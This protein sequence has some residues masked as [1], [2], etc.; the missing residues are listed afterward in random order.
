MKKIKYIFPVLFLLFSNNSTF[1][2]ISCNIPFQIND[3]KTANYSSEIS[4]TVEANFICD[5]PIEP[6]INPP[7]NP[8][9]TFSG[10]DYHLS[11]N[12]I[13]DKP[14]I[15]VEGLDPLNEYSAY[16]LYR[17]IPF[18]LKNG[19]AAT[20]RDIVTI[21]FI[22]NT[23]SLI[24]NA[25][26]LKNF[27]AWLN[28][29]KTG[30]HPN[31]VIGISMGGVIARYALKLM[32]N[33]GAHHDAS[34]YI[35]F[36]SPHRGAFISDDV[37]PAIKRMLDKVNK[38]VPSGKRK[39]NAKKMFRNALKRI[40]STAAHEML[41]THPESTAFYNTLD[42]LGYPNDL[43]R[44]AFAMGDSNANGT[45]I[46]KY[47]SSTL[48][49]YR[50]EVY[51]LKNYNFNI[52]VGTCFRPCDL[53]NGH[54]ASSAGS[55]S[56]V[57]EI[58]DRDLS[59]GQYA[60]IW[61]YDQYELNITPVGFIPTFSALDIKHM[62][63]NVPYSDT[64]KNYSPFDF[65]HVEGGNLAHDAD[66]IAAELYTQQYKIEE[67]IYNYHVPSPVIPSRANKVTPL[68][69]INT[70]RGEWVGAG[71]NILSWSR[72]S[73]ATHYEIHSSK[74]SNYPMQVTTSIGTM[75][76]V[77]QSGYVYVRACDLMTCSYPKSIRVTYSKFYSPF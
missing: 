37:Q 29:Q 17:L 75:I 21:S 62:N 41:V 55:T 54:Y 77:N 11:T 52:R 1:A 53:L 40:D 43:V 25:T 39:D 23:S 13:L 65:V 69:S 36:D 64:I 16:D 49:R 6:P 71:R 45:G 50:I 48:L 72:V 42:N 47:P 56:N 15:V 4:L 58:L 59:D 70:V 68:Q 20:G 2:T 19:L 3:A 38:Y 33:S 22:E 14:V 5:P 9:P 67:Y 46:S 51:Q 74:R 34:L 7:I 27:I 26:N 24:T 63:M 18:Q 32:E 76:S 73:G 35:S 61:D 8:S 12:G 60:P 10:I 66:S 30:A 57:I 28:A 44:V 31:A